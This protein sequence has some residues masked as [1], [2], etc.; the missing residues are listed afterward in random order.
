MEIGDVVPITTVWD[1]AR[2][3]YVGRDR[4]EWR[5]RTAEE[6][7]QVFDDVGLT[8]SFWAVG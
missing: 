2:A 7:A 1:L 4:E 5:P 6:T 3:W 8:G